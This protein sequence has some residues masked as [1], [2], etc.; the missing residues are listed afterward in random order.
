MC[1]LSSMQAMRVVTSNDVIWLILVTTIVCVK[2]DESSEAIKREQSREEDI[3]LGKIRS[4]WYMTKLYLT[5][6]SNNG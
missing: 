2:N 6:S 3:S 4:L 5:T 1:G